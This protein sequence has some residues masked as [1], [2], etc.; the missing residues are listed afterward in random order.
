VS[1]GKRIEPPAENTHPRWT[2]AELLTGI[3]FA[4]A[5]RPKDLLY[6]LDAAK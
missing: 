2:K 1:A 6:A 4:A 3:L 5:E